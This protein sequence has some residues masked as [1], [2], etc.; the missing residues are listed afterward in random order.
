[1]K[2]SQR[3]ADT[4]FSFYTNKEII[5][6][7]DMFMDQIPSHNTMPNYENELFIAF[8]KTLERLK[9]IHISKGEVIDDAPVFKKR[10]LQ[11]V[12]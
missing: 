3:V 11:P 7:E 12:L 6:M 2:H 1:L 4:V 5:E 10:I 8:E 9:Q